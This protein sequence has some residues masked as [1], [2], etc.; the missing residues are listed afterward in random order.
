MLF[1]C[2]KVPEGK[3]GVMER[4]V[5]GAV[6]NASSP[7]VIQDSQVQLV[8]TQLILLRLKREFIESHN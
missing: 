8:E 2:S 1:H 4:V 5:A 7:Y 6:S 3:L